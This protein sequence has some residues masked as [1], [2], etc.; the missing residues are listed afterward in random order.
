MLLVAE[1]VANNS[2][3]YGTSKTGSNRV[4]ECQSSSFTRCGRAKWSDRI[5]PFIPYLRRQLT[6]ALLT[7]QRFAGTERDTT[8]TATGNI[9][10]DDEARPR[11]T[12]RV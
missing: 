7:K 3:N 8:A 6:L 1:S 12:S 5:I 10:S 4:G 11:S 2:S 9:N